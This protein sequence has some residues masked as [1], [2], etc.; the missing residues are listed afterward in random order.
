MK[1]HKILLKR[2]K[3]GNYN[4]LFG[5]LTVETNYGTFYFSTIENY[6]DKK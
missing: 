3:I 1:I 5:T 2:Q 6:K 4:N